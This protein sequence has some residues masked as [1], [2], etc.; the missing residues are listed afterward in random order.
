MCDKCVELGQGVLYIE[1]FLK[2]R[3]SASGY[4]KDELCVTDDVFR[5]YMSNSA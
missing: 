1:H 5:R 2:H 4:I 3:H